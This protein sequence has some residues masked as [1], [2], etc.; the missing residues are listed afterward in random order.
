LAI[1]NYTTGIGVARTIGEIQGILA[2]KGARSIQ[3]N[4]NDSGEPSTVSFIVLF[5]GVP[6]P[7]QLPCNIE[8]VFR[9]MAKEYKE[10]HARRRFESKPEN[11]LQASRVAWRIV[12]DWVEAQMALVEAEQATLAQVFLPYAVVTKGDQ[13]LTMYD[14]FLDTVS[15][16]KALPAGDLS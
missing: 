16:Q 6:I 10:G 2:G 14:R 5:Q 15:K 11:K 4:Y 1:K 8:G 12:K 9:A 3:I 7:F 13:A